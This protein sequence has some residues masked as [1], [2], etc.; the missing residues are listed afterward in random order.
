[1]VHEESLFWNVD[2]SGV[3][4]PRVCEM[5]SLEY[6]EKLTL[7]HVEGASPAMEGLRSL[8]RLVI[9][10]VRALSIR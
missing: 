10:R 5:L 9:L 3:R 4:P 1:M 8:S 2:S 7:A 6:P